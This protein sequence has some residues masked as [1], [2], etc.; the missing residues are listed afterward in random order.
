MTGK[1]FKVIEQE[2]ELY[3]KLNIPASNIYPEI[4]QLIRYRFIPPVEP[5]KSK[6]TECGKEITIYYPKHWD[7]TNIFCDS[8][9]TE[10]VY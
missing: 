2:I 6:C 8:C 7:Y 4:R 5:I 3:N 9:Y 10:A 1:E